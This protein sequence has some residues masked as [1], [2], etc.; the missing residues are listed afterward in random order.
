[1][2]LR[3]KVASCLIIYTILRLHSFR[4]GTNEK[5]RRHKAKKFTYDTM[6]LALPRCREIFNP[7]EAKEATAQLQL[8]TSYRHAGVF[9]PSVTQLPASYFCT[10]NC[11]FIRTTRV[12]H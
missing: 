1:M 12:E 4:R 9:D 5:H 6:V 2:E 7:Q 11:G 3:G 10:K 8:W